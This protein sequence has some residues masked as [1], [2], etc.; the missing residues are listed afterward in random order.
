MFCVATVRSAVPETP[1][2]GINCGTNTAD[3]TSTATSTAEHAHQARRISDTAPSNTSSTAVHGRKLVQA[4]PAP[5][6]DGMQRREHDAGRDDQRGS[7]QAE[8]AQRPAPTRGAAG[9]GGGPA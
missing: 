7:S 6:Q 8:S 9:E 3:H 2:A 4:A 1:V 5:F